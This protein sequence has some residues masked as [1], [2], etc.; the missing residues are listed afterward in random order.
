MGIKDTLANLKGFLTSPSNDYVQN[1]RDFLRV[2]H[3]ELIRKEKY[4][5]RGRDRGKDNLPPTDAEQLDEVERAIKSRFEGEIAGNHEILGEE[6]SVF[7]SRVGSLQLNK[8]PNLKLEFNKALG[9]FKEEIANGLNS[10]RL[11]RRKVIEINEAMDHFK[12]VNRRIDPAMYPDSKIFHLAFIFVLL[13][14]ETVLNGGMLGL[15]AEGG[16]VGGI[17]LALAI[18]VLNVFLFGYFLGKA[19]RYCHH[20]NIVKKISFGVLPASILAGLIF[21]LNFGVAHLRDVLQGVNVVESVGGVVMAKVIALEL[22]VNIES[23]FLFFMG[24]FFAIAAGVDWLKMDDRYP[25]YGELARRQDEEEEKYFEEVRDT[26]ESLGDLHSETG[27]TLLELK[28]NLEHMET[29][30]KSILSHRELKIGQFK[31][32]EAHNI[33]V[34]HQV[35]EVYRDANRKE[36]TTPPPNYFNQ[37]LEIITQPVE[38]TR[39]GEMTIP[40]V[41]SEIKRIIEILE[42]GISE[43]HDA[44][45]EAQEAFKNTHQLAKEQLNLEG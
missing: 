6:L 2:D 40:Q 25:R 9:E 10:A 13:L 8:V 20:V 38:A 39:A 44:W 37:D 45:Q 7:T 11:T 23:G 3:K 24:F 43:I 32:A 21:C 4:E 19:L 36:R 16:L 33:S 42:S 14:V 28:S 35:V 18:A 27:E 22:P 5:K 12:K 1:S 30:F 41:E 31:A 15:G 29:E 17:L 34:A 26:L